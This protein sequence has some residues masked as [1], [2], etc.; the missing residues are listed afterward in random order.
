MRGELSPRLGTGA[1]E[2]NS[3]RLPAYEEKDDFVIGEDDEEEEKEKQ[4]EGGGVE[5]DDGGELPPY[6][7][8]DEHRVSARAAEKASAPG[9]LQ[10][11]YIRPEETLLGLS[12]K[13]NE[14]GEL[15]CQYVS[16]PLPFASC[17]ERS[18]LCGGCCES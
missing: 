5:E 8:G 17:A 16:L 15:L 6:D 1:G 4:E 7:D 3:P 10:V 13:Y 11:H 18:R 9:Q 14:P 12:M 2:A